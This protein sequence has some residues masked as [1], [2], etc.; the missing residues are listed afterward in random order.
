[1]AFGWG[2]GTVGCLAGL[3]A[4]LR[5]DWSAGPSIVAAFILLLALTGVYARLR[6]RA[7]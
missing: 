5:L 7:V 2:F 3:E 6:G 1:V 4:S